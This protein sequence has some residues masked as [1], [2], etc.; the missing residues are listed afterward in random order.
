[1][2]QT[3]GVN[4][5]KSMPADIELAGIVA[6]DDGVGQEAMR[7]DAASQRA[8]GRKPHRIPHRLQIR[9]D[10]GRDAQTGQMCLPSR[11]IDKMPVRLLDQPCDHRRGQ[12]PAAHVVQRLG[13]DHLVAMTGTQKP[14]K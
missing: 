13:I 11:T 5:A 8:L 9:L 1:M 3:F 6:E 12:P 10:A 2:H 4:P 14:I 7:L